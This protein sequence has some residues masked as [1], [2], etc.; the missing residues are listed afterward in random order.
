M[1]GGGIKF[2]T[3]TSVPRFGLQFVSYGANPTE[4]YYDVGHYAGQ[5]LG[6]AKP[7]DLPVQQP[8]RIELVLNLKTGR[9]LGL[10]IS[11][12]V[13]ALADKVIE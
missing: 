4:I 13:L 2:R 5:I 7:Q 3:E 1:P 12:E 6:G 9:E 8:T 11:S 10:Q